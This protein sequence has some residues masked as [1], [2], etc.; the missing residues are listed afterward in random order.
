MNNLP[1]GQC[2]DCGASLPSRSTAGSRATAARSFEEC[3]RQCAACGVGLSN[4]SKAGVETYIYRD[5][6]K[7]VPASVREGFRE[8]LNASANELNRQNKL[9]KS[10][11]STSEDALTWTYFSH[12]R[13]AARLHEL[14]LFPGATEPRLILWGADVSASPTSEVPRVLAEISS[15]LGEDVARRTEPDVILDYG[16]IGIALIEV[17]YRSV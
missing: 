15:D 1:N 7:N 16:A 13:A 8:A 9:L 12:L 11:Y 14:G 4:T 17:K 3:L 5:V 6:A 2:P 10:G